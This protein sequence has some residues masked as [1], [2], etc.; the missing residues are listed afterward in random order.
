MTYVEVQAA[1]RGG[2][3]GPITPCRIVS[4]SASPFSSSSRDLLAADG[5]ERTRREPVRQPATSRQRL[6][7]RAHVQERR[8]HRNA[9]ARRRAAPDPPADYSPTPTG[10]T[11]ELDAGDLHH[12][13]GRQLELHAFLHRYRSS[14][15]T[16]L[17]RPGRRR[18]SAGADRHAPDVRSDHAATP[19]LRPSTSGGLVTFSGTVAPVPGGPQ[20]EHPRAARP[21]RH[22]QHRAGARQPRRQLLRRGQRQQGRLI[23]RRAAGEPVR[24]LGRQ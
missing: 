9:S 12:W 15:T 14:A 16:P 24:R 11:L 2:T 22:E 21:R 10:Q 5:A 17:R 19:R 6:A 3:C 8:D 1:P 20:R 4:A 7:H 18:R 23:R 13:R